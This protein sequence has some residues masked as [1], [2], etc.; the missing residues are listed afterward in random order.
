M[1]KLTSPRASGMAGFR[2]ST[3]LWGHSL[4]VP[5]SW[6]FSNGPVSRSLMFMEP[7]SP[8][9][10]RLATPP[11]PSFLSQWLRLVSWLCLSLDS[12][13]SHPHPQFRE[14]HVPNG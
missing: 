6:G 13:G 11:P 8:S 10:S 7:G 2:G 12:L 9:I 5:L 1:E 3:R 4:S 14:W